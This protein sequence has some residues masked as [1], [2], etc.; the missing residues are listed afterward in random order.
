MNMAKT[1]PYFVRRAAQRWLD[2]RSADLMTAEERA[3]MDA[4]REPE[5]TLE[6][7]SILAA[8]ADTEGNREAAAERLGMGVRT[9]Y[10]RLSALDMHRDVEEQAQRLGHPITPG[11]AP[12]AFPK[13]RRAGLH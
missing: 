7:A 3:L 9:L 5:P 10:S 4:L 12:A 8:L 6:R 1:I 2:T 11:P 13:A